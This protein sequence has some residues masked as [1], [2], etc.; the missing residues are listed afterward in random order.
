MAVPTLPA[1]AMATFTSAH[2]LGRRERGFRVRPASLRAKRGVELVQRV[3]EHGE[4]QHVALLA[5]EV[6]RVEARHARAGDGHDAEASRLLEL[7]ERRPA[8]A[9]GSER[10]TR[11][12]RPVGSDQSPTST[13]GSSR[14]RTWSMV[15]VTVATVGMPRRW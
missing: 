10:S 5:D 1:P 6:A 8:Q 12:S 4:V 7:A 14:R 13:S 2:L 15:Q 3:V 9:S 11:E